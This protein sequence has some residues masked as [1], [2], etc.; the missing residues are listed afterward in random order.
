MYTNNMI[1]FTY[2]MRWHNVVLPYSLHMKRYWITVEAL[3][4]Y[5]HSRRCLFATKTHNDRN[6][7][8]KFIYYKSSSL[9]SLETGWILRMH[10][11]FGYWSWN[12]K[13]VT[14]P[15][16]WRLYRK[17]KSYF[18]DKWKICIGKQCCSR[19]NP[20]LNVFILLF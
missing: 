15:M 17:K 18:Y 10:L 16:S 5:N 20:S 19:K 4:W 8:N 13:C 12:E 2:R 9:Y 6:E 7:L 11:P 1:G 3:H 14:P